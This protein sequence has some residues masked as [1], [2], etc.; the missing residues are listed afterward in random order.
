MQQISNLK[1]RIQDNVDPIFVRIGFQLSFI[2][3][4]LQYGPTNRFYFHPTTVSGEL[5]KIARR[6]SKL[7][8]GKVAIRVYSNP[9]EKPHMIQ[10][11]LLHTL[12]A[13]AIDPNQSQSYVIK[14]GE[15]HLGNATVQ[16]TS[17]TKVEHIGQSIQLNGQILSPR[18]FGYEI[19]HEIRDQSGEY[20][21]Y[22]VLP[23]ESFQRG[24]TSFE[25]KKSETSLNHGFDTAFKY[26]NV[27]KIV[28]WAVGSELYA[29][30]SSENGVLH[31]NLMEIVESAIRTEGYLG[32][33]EIVA[34]SFLELSQNRK[35]L[36]LK[37]N[38][39]KTTSRMTKK[40]RI[41]LESKFPQYK[42]RIAQASY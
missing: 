24:I 28:I 30:T 35:I 15:D 39:I 16:V 2:E 20:L 25:L 26:K 18:K 8:A 10:K 4:M 11:A 33:K 13:L 5:K 21:N 12:V 9:R 23:L 7:N 41:F 1:S 6:I 36:T 27:A 31:A 19:S 3:M 14:V 40:I 32:P 38:D 42:I 37:N 34:V 29:A 17:Q 22:F